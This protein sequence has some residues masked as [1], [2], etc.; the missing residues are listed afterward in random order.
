MNLTG[1]CYCE[2]VRFS[3]E[4]PHPYPYMHC[5]CSICRKM[6]GGG[7]YAINLGAEKSELEVCGSENVT[8]FKTSAA[9]KTD[10]PGERHFCKH[11]G[12]M[13]WVW[14]PRWPELVHPF[15][16]A[17]DTPLPSPPER[18]H[19]FQDSKPDWVPVPEGEQDQRF[20]TYEPDMS[21]AAWHKK[22]GL[23]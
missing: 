5:Y 6:A 23:E 9:G 19:I 8:V 17:I 2:A 7:G 14:D 21:L 4:C 16:S 22:W 15:A 3:V 12:S 1:S 11:C 20:A 13:L 18:F 10:S